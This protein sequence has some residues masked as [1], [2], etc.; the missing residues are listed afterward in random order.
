MKTSLVGVICAFSVAC[1][2]STAPIG[3]NLAVKVT[4]PDLELTNVSPATVYY[5]AIESG[6]AI[7]A[8]WA[9]CADPEKCPGIPAFSSRRL[10]YADIGGYSATATRVVVYWW[11]LVPSGAGFKPDSIRGTVVDL[12]RSGA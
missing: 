10:A 5:F 12:P 4:P 8:N 2:S 1:G 7:R 9:P 11:H 6:L 3:G